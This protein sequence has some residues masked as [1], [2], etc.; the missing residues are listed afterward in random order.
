[1]AR[2]LVVALLCYVALDCSDPMVFGADDLDDDDIVA[3][4]S[5]I[6]PRGKLSPSV[7][8]PPR[9]AALL[10]VEGFAAPDRLV[11]PLRP[12]ERVP[13]QLRPRHAAAPHPSSTSEDH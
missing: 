2:L 12:L 1:M 11:T 10:H 5:P 13:P 4:S 8:A 3:A 9:W 6:E 7:T